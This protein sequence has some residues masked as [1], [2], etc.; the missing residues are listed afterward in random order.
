M[1]MGHS[2][3]VVR[4]LYRYPAIYVKVFMFRG[5]KWR[6]K[7]RLQ[8]FCDKTALFFISALNYKTIILFSLME[9]PLILVLGD[10]PHDFVG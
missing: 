6:N 10:I 5:A 8:L 9:Y 7:D 3:F 1:V 2:I 4:T